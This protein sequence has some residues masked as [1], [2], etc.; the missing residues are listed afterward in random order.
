MVSAAA[1][2]E[3]WAWGACIYCDLRN[4]QRLKRRHDDRLR[5]GRYRRQLANS[6][7]QWDG[8]LLRV[9]VCYCEQLQ[10]LQSF[11]VRNTCWFRDIPSAL[12]PLR[13][14][15]RGT[16]YFNK[17]EYKNGLAG[18]THGCDAMARNCGQNHTTFSAYRLHADDPLVVSRLLCQWAVAC[19]Q[20]STHSAPPPCMSN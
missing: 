8:R 5:L 12:T 2:S 4:L 6:A 16:Y 9:R 14:I 19:T 1:P 7:L 18:M 11:L 13:C 15:R 20:W 17:G 3:T 10:Q